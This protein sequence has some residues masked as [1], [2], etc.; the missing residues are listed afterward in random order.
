MLNE[1]GLEPGRL[2]LEITEGIILQNTGAVMETLKRLHQ[3]GVSIAMDDF[4]TGYSSLA[5][6]T[7]FPV[8]KIKID[9]SFIIRSAPARRP[10]PSCRASSGSAS[11]CT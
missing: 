9:R 5:Y 8:K 3:L 11:R 7:R 4:G 2:E 1:T 10:R 6:L